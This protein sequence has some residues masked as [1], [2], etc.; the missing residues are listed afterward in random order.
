MID[1]KRGN[2]VLKRWRNHPVLRDHVADRADFSE[3][4]EEMVA[5]WSPQISGGSGVPAAPAAAAGANAAPI[6]VGPNGQRIIL[7]DG[8]WVPMQ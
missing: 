4:A 7:R 5:K 6:A 2:D 3:P 1:M 8:K